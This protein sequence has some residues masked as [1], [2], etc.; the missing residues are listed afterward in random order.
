MQRSKRYLI[1]FSLTTIRA[2]RL[3]ARARSCADG[4]LA[5]RSQRVSRRSSIT[6]D[7]STHDE[8]REVLAP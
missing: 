3:L 4:S 6:R 8:T 2:I 5:E 7:R 1:P